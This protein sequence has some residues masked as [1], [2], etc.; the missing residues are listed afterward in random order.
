MCIRDSTE[1]MQ[2]GSTAMTYAGTGG[3]LYWATVVIRVD[4]VPGTY[5]VDT[6]SRTLVTRRKVG[7]KAGFFPQS[8][9]YGSGRVW[10]YNS[11]ASVELSPDV[12]LPDTQVLQQAKAD[13]HGGVDGILGLLPCAT[14]SKRGLRSVEVDFALQQVHW[15]RPPVHPG[16]VCVNPAVHQHGALRDR[17]WLRGAMRIVALDGRAFEVPDVHMMLDTG[18]TKSATFFRKGFQELQECARHPRLARLEVTT[19]GTTLRMPLALGSR[20]PVCLPHRPDQIAFVIVGL[21]ALDALKSLRFELS[22][23]GS[24]I[25]RLCIAQ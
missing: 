23:D 10:G 19:R 17:L 2:S 3:A 8:I 25:T 6:G 5:V 9:L 21:Q 16:S 22:A 13:L 1:G 7:S 24:T 15:N 20:W 18:A 11:F 4:G 12:A 14:T